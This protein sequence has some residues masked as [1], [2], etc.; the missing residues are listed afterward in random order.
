MLGS[1]I[2]LTAS[3]KNLQLLDGTVNGQ[4]T[5]TTLLARPE[6]ASDFIIVADAGG[7]ELSSNWMCVGVS[8][9]ET[10]PTPQEPDRSPNLGELR[11]R[12]RHPLPPHVRCSTNRHR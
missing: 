5:P 10:V 6:R 7:A 11:A 9:L 3:E 8:Q 12:Q 2:R 4:N 1:R